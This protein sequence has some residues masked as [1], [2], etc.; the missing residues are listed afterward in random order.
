MFEETQSL[1]SHTFQS[2]KRGLRAEHLG[3]CK[4]LCT[5]LGW[6]SDM[7]SGG[8]TMTSQNLSVEEAK[9]NR[10]DLILWPPVVLIHSCSSRIVDR[11]H[12]DFVESSINGLLK[13]WASNYSYSYYF[14]TN[15]KF[16]SLH[17]LYKK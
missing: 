8:R 11:Q 15:L 17:Y 3:L 6:N 4:A 2:R 5:V 9:A 16:I 14:L 10:E 12:Q 13:G 1:I 7:D